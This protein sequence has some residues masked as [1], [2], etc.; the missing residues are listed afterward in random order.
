MVFKIGFIPKRYT[1]SKYENSRKENIRYLI[2][3]DLIMIETEECR[4]V[5][6]EH[7]SDPFRGVL[8]QLE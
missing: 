3:D 2:I 1:L 8:S 6:Y 5:R 4:V 7:I